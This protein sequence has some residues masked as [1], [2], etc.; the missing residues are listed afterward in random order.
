MSSKKNIYGIYQS[1]L[2][3]KNLLSNQRVNLF[4]KN[5][6]LNPNEDPEYQRLYKLNLE[7]P[8]KT[9]KEFND[10]SA[11]KDLNETNE[12]NAIFLY[13][14]L[15]KFRMINADDKLKEFWIELGV[16]NR[17]ELSLIEGMLYLI[18]EDWKEEAMAGGVNP[19]INNSRIAEPNSKLLSRCKAIIWAIKD[20]KK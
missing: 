19:R 11:S 5:P 13:N 1:M 3:K 18:I 9:L 16:N 7:L 10:F 17:N 15:L 14:R 20:A 6:S 12:E 8:K 4:R 2:N